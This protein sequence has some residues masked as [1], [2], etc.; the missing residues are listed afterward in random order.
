MNVIL[1]HNPRCSK[2]RQTLALLHKNGVQPEIIEYLKTPP[3]FEKLKDLLAKLGLEPKNIVR[4]A[5]AKE[6]GIDH[7]VGDSLLAALA[8]NPAA[9]QRPIAVCGDRA[10]I[11]RPPENVLTLLSSQ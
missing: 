5:E 9:L 1:Y 7:L 6:A 4:P 11:G 8:E 10:V 2:S 3:D